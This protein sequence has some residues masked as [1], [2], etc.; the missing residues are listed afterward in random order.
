MYSISLDLDQKVGEVGVWEV[1]EWQWRL[2]W[3]HARFVWES[4]QEEE[5]LR[6]ISKVK[7]NREVKDEQVWGSEE[8]FTVKSAYECLTNHARGSHDGLFK[9]LW[10]VKALLNVLIT[11]WRVLLDRIPNGVCLIRIRVVV[12][13]TTCAMC[14]AS[15]ETT[16]HLFLECKYAQCVWSMCFRWID[17]MFVQHNNL[18]LYKKMIKNGKKKKCFLFSYVY[19]TSLH[20]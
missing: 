4:A 13:T 14:Q 11:V 8:P 2:K 7:L 17:I 16:H 19:I 9:N 3:R 12:N 5:L 20:V 10:K 18:K 1:S 15:D 6:Y